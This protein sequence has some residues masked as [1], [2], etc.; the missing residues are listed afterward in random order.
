MYNWCI[1]LILLLLEIR[2]IGIQVVNVF[3]LF[4]YFRPIFHLRMHRNRLGAGLCAP[5]VP[6]VEPGKR[7]GF[8]EQEGMGYDGY[9]IFE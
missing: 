2:D 9:P 5:T 8:E 1:Q 7:K 3:E 6:T 4:I